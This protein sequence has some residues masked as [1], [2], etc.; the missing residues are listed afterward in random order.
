M[1]IPRDAH[2][3]AVNL[4]SFCHC[5]HILSHFCCIL[6]QPKKG[7]TFSRSDAS[8]SSFSSSEMLTWV[9]GISSTQTEGASMNK[10]WGSRESCDQVSLYLQVLSGSIDVLLV[11]WVPWFCPV[12]V[13][14]DRD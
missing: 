10:P 14:G 13:D 3:M 8:G 4:I 12:R 7:D 11:V 5:N 9:L 2:I 1:E 6:D